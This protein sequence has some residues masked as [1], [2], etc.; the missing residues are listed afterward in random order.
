M[1]YLPRYSLSPPFRARHAHGRCTSRKSW[2]PTRQP[3]L[4]SCL[5]LARHVHSS[6]SPQN[7]AAGGFNPK[8]YV[9]TLSASI[10]VRLAESCPQSKCIGAEPE[11]VAPEIFRDGTY[12]GPAADSYSVGHIVFHMYV[13][14]AVL[15]R[16]CADRRLRLLG[17]PAHS[18]L[19]RATELMGL[20]NAVR[21]RDPL[22]HQRID[23]NCISAN[24]ADFINAL[25]GRAPAMRTLL[26]QALTH[27][28]LL[29]HEPLPPMREALWVV[30][31][32]TPQG[33][34]EMDKGSSEPP[35]PTEFSSCLSETPRATTE[36]EW[37]CA[38]S[39]AHSPSSSS[40]SGRTAT[41]RALR[42]EGTEPDLSSPASS[43]SLSTA[44]PRGS[45]ERSHIIVAADAP[46]FKWALMP[47]AEALSDPPYRHE[48]GL[49]W[50]ALPGSRAAGIMTKGKK[51]EG[52]ST[53]GS[54]SSIF[55]EPDG[56]ET[57]YGT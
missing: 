12:Y 36:S 5:G 19:G 38:P 43:V 16:A 48:F 41:L 14:H 28:W 50:L 30:R 31:A 44:V 49:D 8:W 2:S 35:S 40:T 15:T 33:N 39:L 23:E 21:A 17:R 42:S 29:E 26:Q 10:W 53:Y 34:W 51:L 6:L 52:A 1:T 57:T 4:S 11:F 7:R 22:A 56:E 24:A 46:L 9:H 27:P 25:A 20:T 18:D 37:S 55:G 54:M 13:P 32:D 3:C 45:L 47:W